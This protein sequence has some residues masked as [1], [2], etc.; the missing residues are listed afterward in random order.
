MNH[1][2]LV[3]A[4]AEEVSE[5]S[6]S[7]TDVAAVIAAIAVVSTAELRTGGEVSLNGLGKLSTKTR[8]GRTGRNPKTGEEIQ[9]PAKTVVHFSATKLLR[10]AVGG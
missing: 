5:R 4:V 7:K 6:L 2:E 10:D 3:S 1:A 9:I 8:A